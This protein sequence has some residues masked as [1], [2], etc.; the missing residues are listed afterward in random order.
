MITTWEIN[1]WIFNYLPMNSR[2]KSNTNISYN[3]EMKVFIFRKVTSKV[4]F[5][6]LSSSFIFF[7]LNKAIWIFSN[8]LPR[9]FSEL[10]FL[11]EMFKIHHVFLSFS[12]TFIGKQRAC[13]ETAIEKRPFCMAIVYSAHVL[14]TKSDRVMRSVIKNDV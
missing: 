2:L 9:D 14:N 1:L 6:L 13:S 7:F 11:W 8:F 5:I 10:V 12:L 4:I 3:I